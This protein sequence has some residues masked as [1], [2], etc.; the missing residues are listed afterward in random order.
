MPAR[1]PVAKLSSHDLQSYQCTYRSLAHVEAV[2]ANEHNLARQQAI[3]ADTID[4]TPKT[5]AE[6]MALVGELVLAVFDISSIED[7][8]LTAKGVAT[9]AAAA[10]PFMKGNKSG[11]TTHQVERMA[12]KLL[13]SS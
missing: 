7:K 9:P 13:V 6:K 12:W 3:Q 8:P 2:K 11:I 4:D 1:T 10:R 5:Q